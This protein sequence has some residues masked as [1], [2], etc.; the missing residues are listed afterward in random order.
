VQF[1]I[2][3]KTSN[4]GKGNGWIENLPQMIKTTFKTRTMKI[5]CLILFHITFKKERQK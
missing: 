2:F 1:S 4:L 5:N 3:K